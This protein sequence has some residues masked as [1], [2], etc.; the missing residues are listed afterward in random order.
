ML[1]I[2][3]VRILYSIIILFW[4]TL[5]AAIGDN[6]NGTLVPRPGDSSRLSVVRLE[7]DLFSVKAKNIPLARVLEE[8]TKQTDAKIVLKTSAD[9][10]ISIDLSNLRLEETLKRLTHGFS[11]VFLYQPS[12]VK[13]GSMEIEKFILY[14]KIGQNLK[15][16]DFKN[17]V[18]EISAKNIVS[19]VI[20][21]LYHE[22]QG[23]LQDW[24]N[25]PDPGLR[26]KAI[27]ILAQS[28]D[29]TAIDYLVGLLLNDQ[30]GTVRAGAAE[31]LGDLHNEKGLPVLKMALDEED[32]EVRLNAI[33]ALGNFNDEKIT[34]SLVPFL[35]D[36]H[37]DI[38]TA[39][40]MIL[41]DLGG[42]KAME[43]VAK[44]LDDM[45]AGVR[46]AA[47]VTLA[48]IRE[49]EMNNFLEDVQLEELKGPEGI[50]N[51]IIVEKKL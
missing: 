51:D 39:V 26:L 49:V 6:D 35:E 47:K 23:Q 7:H 31:A 45:D 16:Q 4:V 25:S 48:E 2:A 22:S 46:E 1:K 29:E 42:E 43:L 14:G 38:R 32:T 50:D 40:I 10:T 30:N 5:T 44:A 24:L 37:P 15:N 3:L 13:T 8:L 11:R 28:E 27:G 19:P 12:K 17:E 21:T 20:K 41:R 34:M 33:V 18:N 9:A 36:S